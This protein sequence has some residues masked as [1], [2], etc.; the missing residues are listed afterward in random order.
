MQSTPGGTRNELVE[1]TAGEQFAAQFQ[2]DPGSLGG[3][4]GL[5][6]GRNANEPVSPPWMITKTRSASGPLM[7]TGDGHDGKNN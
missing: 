5:A 1:F 7:A 4:F 3:A 6:I 2:V